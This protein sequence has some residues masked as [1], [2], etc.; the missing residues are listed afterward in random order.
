ML[1]LS[2]IQNKAY[3]NKLCIV[4]Y[5]VYCTTVLAI[6]TIFD[7][8]S[9]IHYWWDNR[10][11]IWICHLF[12]STFGKWDLFCLKFNNSCQLND[13]KTKL[14]FKLLNVKHCTVDSWITWTS[15]TQIIVF[16]LKKLIKNLFIT[17]QQNV[18]CWPTTW[19]C[20]ESSA[21]I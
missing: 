6:S 7:S 15:I 8:I 4:L 21:I 9:F 13:L 19:S 1:I 16:S 20:C 18:F 17:S 2:P 14:H 12:L 11:A 3:P 10:T 5:R